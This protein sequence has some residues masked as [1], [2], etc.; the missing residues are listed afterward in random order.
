MTPAPDKQSQVRA[1]G[2]A[3]LFG[4]G[5]ALLVCVTLLVYW[6]GLSGPFLLDDFGNLDPLGNDGGI[7]SLAEARAFVFGNESGPTGRPVAMLSF[8]MDAQDWPPLV[9]A[10]KYTN[11]MIHLLCGLSLCWLVLLLSRRLAFTER[12]GLLLALFVAGLWLL[13]PLNISTTLYVVQRMTQLMALFALLALVCF[14]Q[15][16]EQMLAGGRGALWLLACLFPFG[17]LSVLSK[18][19][20]ALLLALIVILELTLFRQAPRPLLYRC[21]LGFGV[22]LPLAVVFVYLLL[23]AP[24]SLRLYEIREFS[25]VERLLTETRVLSDYLFSIFLPSLTDGTVFH[26]DIALSRGLWSPPSTLFSALF[27]LGLLGS[28]VVLLRSQPV[29]SLAVFWYFTLQLL[30]STYVPLELYFEH[31][32]YLAMVG[33]L[34]AAGYYLFRFSLAERRREAQQGVQI[35]VAILFILGLWSSWNL[36]RIWAEAGTFH[37]YWAE[38][39]PDSIRAQTAY[40]DYLNT[41]ELPELAMERLQVAYQHY[42]NEVTVQLYLWNQACQLHIDPPISIEEMLANPELEF[43]RDDITGHL[44]VL[45]ENLYTGECPYPDTETL[46]RLFE[47]LSRLPSTEDRLAGLYYLLSDLHVFYGNLDPALIA[48]AR[49][50]EHRDSAEIPIRQAMLSASAGN[51]SDALVFLDRAAAADGRR[52]LLQPSERSEIARL[53]ESFQRA[54]RSPTNEPAN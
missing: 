40:A 46:V 43:W 21:W 23:S 25:L 36:S 13:H 38:R 51:F 50:F 53:R 15:G 34:F 54:M 3:A 22:L 10:M 41:L 24:E 39:K 12:Q 32:N 4:V 6:P 17:L 29:F 5:L 8:L 31:R 1:Q 42:P 11:L 18:E 14:L 16:R 9:G 19:N 2:D 37:A 28:A 49:A 35:V 27:L 52:D 20:G 44:R 26:D 47:R 30:E 7:D 45:V 33:P 48:L